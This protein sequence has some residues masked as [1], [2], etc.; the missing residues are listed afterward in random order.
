M[1]DH[2]VSSWSSTGPVG[3]VRHPDDHEP[4]VVV[5]ELPPLGQPPRPRGERAG[6]P[7]HRLHLGG[8]PVGRLVGGGDEQHR[9]RLGRPVA[10]VV[11]QLQ[12]L[13]PAVVLGQAGEQDE[14]VRGAPPPPQAP[15]PGAELAAQVL[16]EGVHQQQLQ[17]VAGVVAAARLGEPLGEPDE[18]LGV[19]GGEDRLAP[20]PRPLPSHADP[21][22]EPQRAGG[23]AR[24]ERHTGR[25]HPRRLARFE[26]VAGA[27][28]VPP[29]QEGRDRGA[30]VDT[31]I[32]RRGPAESHSTNPN[33][34]NR[35][36]RW[37]PN[38]S[39]ARLRR[40]AVSSGSSLSSGTVP[41][42]GAVLAPAARMSALALST[43]SVACSTLGGAARLRR[44]SRNRAHWQASSPI[45]HTSGRAR[46]RLRFQLVRSLGYGFSSTRNGRGRFTS[47]CTVLSKVLSPRKTAPPTVPPFSSAPGLGRV[48]RWRAEATAVGQMG[49]TPETATTADVAAM[50]PTH[51]PKLPTVHLGGRIAVWTNSDPIS[52]MRNAG[53][54]GK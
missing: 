49:S 54:G 31:V 24:C 21:P 39:A 27:G 53:P 11:D 1:S 47:V 50:D 18:G 32:R 41:L 29:P 25:G 38:R 22:L 7:V 44:F 34:R 20:Q 51:R 3:V 43:S 30:L 48:F 36:I 46:S 12:Q 10:H 5:Q 45:R 19:A 26:R 14:H 13:P 42:S 35:R 40:S 4:G 17:L 23:R 2:A 8:Q 15:G 28:P 9:I 16:E 37:L 33:M 52:D 6:Q